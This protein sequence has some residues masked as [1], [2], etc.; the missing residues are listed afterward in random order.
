MTR[1]QKKVSGG[2]F[3]VGASTAPVKCYTRAL[4]YNLLVN[5]TQPTSSRVHQEKKQERVRIT[6]KKMKYTKYVFYNYT[7]RNRK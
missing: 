5:Q 7:R 4:R 6:R 2:F 3:F 1:R